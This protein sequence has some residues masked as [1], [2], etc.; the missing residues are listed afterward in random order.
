MNRVLAWL[1]ELVERPA[2]KGLQA[3]STLLGWAFGGTV[4]LLALLLWTG[5]VRI[6]PTLAQTATS[7]EEDRRTA[8]AAM[9]RAQF[10]LEADTRTSCVEDPESPNPRWAE[11]YVDIRDALDQ[12]ERLQRV[13]DDI[14][15]LSPDTAHALGWRIAVGWR[16]ADHVERRLEGRDPDERAAL[17][18]Y[19]CEVLLDRN[20]MDV[21]ID[22]VVLTRLA[23]RG[24]SNW[25]VQAP[26][27]DDPCQPRTELRG[28]VQ[29]VAHQP[30]TLDIVLTSGHRLRGPTVPMLP[31]ADVT[32]A[33][34][35]QL[36]AQAEATIAAT[37]PGCGPP[38][39]AGPP[40][41]PVPDGA[42]IELAQT[43]RGHGALLQDIHSVVMR[44]GACADAI[45]TTTAHRQAALAYGLRATPDCENVSAD[46]WVSM[47]SGFTTGD[48]GDVSL[49]M[50]C[51]DIC[52]R[53]PAPGLPSPTLVLRVASAPFGSCTD[54]TDEALPALFGELGGHLA[55]RAAAGAPFE[56]LG[57]VG[58]AN[59]LDPC[60]GQT[61]LG[62]AADRAVAMAAA[63]H[64]GAGDEATRVRVSARVQ[65]AGSCPAEHGQRAAAAQAAHEPWRRVDIEFSG[66]ALDF[67]RQACETRPW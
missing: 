27:D 7:T 50:R 34:S 61:N 18:G 12:A 42:L 46:G 56:R 25:D 66:P 52:G 14:L 8:E 23:W 38:D 53:C 35:G 17:R 67:D 48:L 21:G 9:L 40:P 30:A 44:G 41:S 65:E 32:G 33:A 1:A 15:R 39:T 57:V 20:P 63:I 60:A 64:G 59:H 29:A 31:T 6:E 19:A 49:Q 22:S 55:G 26:D 43:L 24:D 51:V 5:V 11:G 4:L 16:F 2:I 58:W 28:L 47:R 54:T 10:A 13:L 3:I 45:Q 36:L 37:A 62:I